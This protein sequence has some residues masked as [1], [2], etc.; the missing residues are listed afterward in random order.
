M[1]AST[2]P[3]IPMRKPELVKAIREHGLKSVSAV[4]KALADPSRRF[5]LDLLFERDGRT[6]GEIANVVI[7]AK[8]GNRISGRMIGAYLT[9]ANGRAAL[10]APALDEH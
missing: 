1:S 9:G 3:S 2:V 5:L 10:Y 8:S 6:L 4:F 7:D